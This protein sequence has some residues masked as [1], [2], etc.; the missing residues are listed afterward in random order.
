MQ[1]KHTASKRAEL[2][3]LQTTDRH[4]PMHFQHGYRCLGSLI[5]EY[6]SFE[7]F[8]LGNCKH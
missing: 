6:E 5:P 2:A 4:L 3:Q 8:L 7:A 1:W